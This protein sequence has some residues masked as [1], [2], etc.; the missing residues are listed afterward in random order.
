MCTNLNK[1]ILG[2]LDVYK[3]ILGVLDVYKSK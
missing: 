2:V 1:S 3:S